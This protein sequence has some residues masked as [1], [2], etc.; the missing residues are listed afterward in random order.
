MPDTSEMRDDNRRPFLN[1]V[2]DWV[3]RK[4]SKGR[5]A[6]RGQWTLKLGFYI[7]LAFL[8]MTLLGNLFPS[9]NGY[10]PTLYRDGP[11]LEGPSAAHWM[12]TDQL[13]RDVFSRI[14]SG[15][16]ASLIVAFAAVALSMTIGSLLGWI[17]G[18]AG[19][20]LDRVLSLTMDAIYSFP[21]M[22]LA[23]VLVAM[24]GSGMAPMIWAVGFVYIPTY[25]RVTRAEVLQVRETSYIEAVR[26]IGAGNVRIV[27]RHV[28][29]NTVNAI[30]A[31]SSFNLA[32]AILTVA[33]LSFLGY[34][35][36]PP[37]ADWGFDIQ[38]GQKFL[39]SGGWWLI[40]FPGLMIISLS[41][42]F[43]LIG[44]GISDLLN[45]K[46]RRKKI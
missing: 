26:S 41:L 45:P 43:G 6:L 16:K 46:R 23:I 15:G 11:R 37:A 33:A 39:Q 28:A 2:I 1:L 27:M 30:M 10:H 38:N 17:S 7:V 13:Q 22:I 25:F 24:F 35:L 42:G 12:G 36:P 18:F 44:E 14:L 31:V 32:D 5:V 3:L 4:L 9:L 8:I 29:P 19:G 40:T 20:W 34:G 21:S